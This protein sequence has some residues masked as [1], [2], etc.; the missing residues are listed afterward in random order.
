MND[1]TPL[2]VKGTISHKASVSY[3]TP[4]CGLYLY[5]FNF[6][7]QSWKYAVSLF[8]GQHDLHLSQHKVSISLFQGV[9]QLEGAV[10]C[11][12]EKAKLHTHTHTHPRRHKR[13]K[14]FE[15]LAFTKNDRIS[16]VVRTWTRKPSDHRGLRAINPLTRTL[17]FGSWGAEKLS[18]M[19]WEISGCTFVETRQFL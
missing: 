16:F 17:I 13:I 5:L 14:L 8:A 15:I 19:Y 12:T 4:N 3:T 11:N 10:L 6:I 18:G 1:G 2:G 7:Q 9:N